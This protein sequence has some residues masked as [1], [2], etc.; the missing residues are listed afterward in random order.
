M[1][2][3]VIRFP[4]ARE[5]EPEPEPDLRTRTGNLEPGTWNRQAK[6]RSPR[7]YE[8]AT[9]PVR[10][11]P[12][13]C[14]SAGDSARQRCR[15]RTWI[16]CFHEVVHRARAPFRVLSVT[17][18]RPVRRI[19]GRTRRI[20]IK[21][22][23]MTETPR[24]LHILVLVASNQ[25]AAMVECALAQARAHER[26]PD[27]IHIVASP[28]CVAHVHRELLADGNG[29]TRFVAVCSQLGVAR[30]EIL[31]NQRTLHAVRTDAQVLADAA[32]RLFQ[33][34]R[35]LGSGRHR[36]VTV[37]V[38]RD[39]AAL[40]VLAH[41]AMQIVGRPE[42]RFFVEVERAPSSRRSR[43]ELSDGGWRCAEVPLLLWH[44]D[45]APVA[46]YMDAV[47]AQRVERQRLER[48]DPLRLDL[49]QR[50]VM[51][52][53]TD[54][55]MPAMQFFWLYYLAASP[56]ERFP[57]LEISTALSAS[58]RPS[59]VFTQKLSSGTTRS[60]PADLQRAFGRV[61]PHAQDKFDAMFLRSC[62]PHP[63]L[64]STIS[65]INAALRRALGRGAAP[66]LIKGGRGNGGYRV[67]LD[68][69]FIQI[70]E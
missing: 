22:R 37:V 43:R 14:V 13:P 28:E 60:F 7:A 34:F 44:R 68:R 67:T 20:G 12:H 6:L 64:P 66:Y 42:D 1:T 61:F 38:A 50:R 48:P 51:I 32:E 2:A 69:S 56:G 58:R 59:P 53:A 47:G 26:V 25:G 3:P 35:Q 41:A 62:G 4:F 27:E 10:R 9:T 18:E 15:Q 30:D 5:P 31:L 16:R 19:A 57:L 36:E 17:H 33:L 40:G 39:A 24:P 65:K 52:G 11:P 55:P 21:P 54:V 63:G 45:D 49:R 29:A 70:V 23:P 8:S 46:H